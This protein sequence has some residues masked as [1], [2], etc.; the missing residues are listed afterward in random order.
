MET[1]VG[2]HWIDLRTAT[3]GGVAFEAIR[4]TEAVCV[5]IITVHAGVAKAQ[6]LRPHL[7]LRNVQHDE[8]KELQSVD[9]AV[10]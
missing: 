5:N 3:S 8:S 9:V 7:V 2:S 10:N 4:L 6:S 1:R